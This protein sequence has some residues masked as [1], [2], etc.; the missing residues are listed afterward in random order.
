MSRKGR[1]KIE[2]DSWISSD[3]ICYCRLIVTHCANET[4]EHKILL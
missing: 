4:E 2:N 1:E 3:E